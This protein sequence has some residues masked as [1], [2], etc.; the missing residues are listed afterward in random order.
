[1]Q[2]KSAILLL[3]SSMVLGGCFKP[4]SD[5]PSGAAAYDL[6]PAA[7]ASAARES[8]KIGLLDVLSIRVFQEPDLSFESIQVDAAG[9]FNFPLVGEVDAVGMTPIELSNLLE[10]S[11]GERYIRDPQVVVGV[12]SSAAQRVTVEGNV[13]EPGVYEITGSSSL[14]E[15]IARAQGLTRLAVVDEIVVLRTVDGQPMGAVF[16][17]QAI[18]E[19][20]VPD[21]EILGGDKIVVGFSGLKGV[22]RDLLQAGSLFNVFRAL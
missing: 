19:G 2:L 11:L 1:M 10:A 21:P 20:R 13:T 5:L 7:N 9:S 4:S 8:Y 16:D 14:L 12:I 22:Y 6:I 18:R 3:A 17:L 15:A